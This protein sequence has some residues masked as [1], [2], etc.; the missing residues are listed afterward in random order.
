MEEPREQSQEQQAGSY[1]VETITLVESDF[2]RRVIIDFT[3]PTN[4][5]IDI[6]TEISESDSNSKIIVSVILKVDSTQEEEQI[7]S[8]KVKMTGVFSKN[9]SPQL[10]EDI[11]KKVN[12]PAIIYPFIREHVATTCAKAGL[13]HIFIPPVNFVERNKTT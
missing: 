11:F 12:A 5:N 2:S 13:G 8:I 10:N 7:F 1:N 9:G 4:N 3:K 6:L